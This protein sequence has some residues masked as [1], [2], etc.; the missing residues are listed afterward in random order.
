MHPINYGGAY[1]AAAFLHQ[2]IIQDG[3]SGIKNLFQEL[4]S[5]GNDLDAALAATAGYTSQSGFA[6]DFAER[7]LEFA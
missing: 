4:N 2:E 5:N 1:I 7:G 6:G 3:G